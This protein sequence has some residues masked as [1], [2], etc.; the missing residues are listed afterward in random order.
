MDRDLPVEQTRDL[1]SKAET[2]HIAALNL[3][4]TL[5]VFH[6]INDALED[7]KARGCCICLS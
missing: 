2:V 7:G 4:N 3:A 6:G 1:M 5:G